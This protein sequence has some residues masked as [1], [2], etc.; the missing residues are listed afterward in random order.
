[1]RTNTD[2]YYRPLL[3]VSSFTF[4]L[5]LARKRNEKREGARSPRADYEHCAPC[6]DATSEM[7]RAGPSLQQD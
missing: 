1:M 3:L 7:T 4:P 5:S 2:S 6:S